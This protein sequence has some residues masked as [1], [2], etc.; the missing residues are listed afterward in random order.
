[1]R[2]NP[3]RRAAALLCYAWLVS[4]PRPPHTSPPCPK[5]AC[6]LTCPQEYHTDSNVRFVVTLPE[7][8]MH[9]ALAAG[10]LDKFKLRTK[11]SIGN[12]MLF[13]AEVG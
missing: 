11:I 7:A 1:M 4:L 5:F 8:K 10:L 2:D 9:E 13:N 12:M 3:R 6:T